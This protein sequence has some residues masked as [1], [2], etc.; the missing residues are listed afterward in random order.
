MRGLIR[1]VDDVVDQAFQPLRRVKA[2][3]WA[4][5]AASEAADYSI[6]WHAISLAIAVVSPRR[7]RHALRLAVMLGV[8]SVAVNGGL[9]RL[10]RRAR[11]ALLE[12][13]P[14]EV[15]R[16]RTSSFPSGHASSAALAAVLFTDAVPRLRPLWVT[17]AAIVSASRIHNRMH[18]ASDVA[19]GTALGTFFGMAAKK[20]WPL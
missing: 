14:Y 16:P 4:F 19:A 2:A 13:R 12:D 11:P 5:Y 6:A 17:L 10:T 8:E 18:H 15:R 20:L 1:T 7:R 3:N 9:K